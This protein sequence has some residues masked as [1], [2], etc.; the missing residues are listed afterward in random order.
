M[1]LLPSADAEKVAALRELL[2]A[3]GAGIYLDS[4]SA[5]PLPAETAAA[6]R[7][8]DEWELRVG[9]AAAGRDEDVAQREAEA[10]AVLAALIGAQPDE[11]LPVAGVGQG[12]LLGLLALPWRP[13][14]TLAVDGNYDAGL[15]AAARLACSAM[16]VTVEAVHDGSED[17]PAGTRR[18]LLPAVSPL[19]GARADLQ[20]LVPSLRQ[21]GV[22]LILDA[23]LLTGV[24]PVAVTDTG[25]E[26]LVTATDRWALGPECTAAIWLADR[27]LRDALPPEALRLPRSSLLGLAR[28]IGWLEMY[29]GIEWAYAR[30]ARLAAWLAD[31]LRQI[32]GVQVLTPADSL[33]GVVSFALPAAWDAAQATDE[34]GRQVFAIVAPVPHLNAVRASVAWFNTEDELARFVAAVAE[35]ARHTPETLPRR[36]TLNVL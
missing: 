24:A 35:L 14:D 29:V 13:G 6:L 34:L 10:R 17:L 5:G 19:T 30:T 16:G 32:A 7:E 8:A 1:S 36:Q 28:S 27:G 20:R 26:V 9:R 23:S 21:R 33:A 25:A 22:E 31:A 4:A 18:L 2:P 11:V 3:T 12:L 15:V